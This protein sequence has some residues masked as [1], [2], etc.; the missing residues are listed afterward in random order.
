[1]TT[2]LRCIKPYSTSLVVSAAELGIVKPIETTSTSRGHRGSARQP[3][4]FIC[5]KQYW[6]T[7][8]FILNSRYLERPKIYQPIAEVVRKVKEVRK[9]L[10]I[11]TQIKTA[12]KRWTAR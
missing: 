9:D 3:P 4:T 12:L 10:K 1:M 6:Y 7:N 11:D 8:C 5:G 2:Y